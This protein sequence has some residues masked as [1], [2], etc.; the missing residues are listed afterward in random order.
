VKERLLLL[1]DTFLTANVLKLGSTAVGA[2]FVL[3]G[4]WLFLPFEA[5]V[6]LRPDYSILGFLPE[7][8]IAIGFLLVGGTT[9]IG[10]W[11]DSTHWARI[12]LYGITSWSLF[13]FTTYLLTFWQSL[14]TPT[15]LATAVLGAL[16]VIGLKKRELKVAF[17][18]KD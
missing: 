13:I 18:N 9:L 14:N 17:G 6:P 4:L 12:G 1:R 11:R 5:F 3:I 7:P 8:A 2:W 15:Y 10:C 16:L